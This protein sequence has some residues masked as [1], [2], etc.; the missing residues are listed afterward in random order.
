MHA[1]FRF[2]GGAGEEIS[3]EL[4]DTSRERFEEVLDVL[5]SSI[6]AGQFPYRPGEASFGSFVNCRYCDFDAICPKDRDERWEAV[7]LSP[8][9][10]RYRALA[11]D[12]PDTAPSAG[13]PSSIPAGAGQ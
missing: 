12:A 1:A 3:L 7:R 10:A 6:D 8:G 2:L 5:V 13:S 9:L 11:E 4:N